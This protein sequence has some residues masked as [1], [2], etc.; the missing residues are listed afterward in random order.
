[1]VAIVASKARLDMGNRDIRNGSC[2]CPSKRAR[3]VALNDDEFGSDPAERRKNGPGNR[4]DMRVR[5][6]PPVAV[7]ADLAVKFEP[8]IGRTKLRMLAGKDQQRW[9][10]ASRKSLRDR[11]ELDGF[12]PG[13]DDQNN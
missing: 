3:C 6:D 12:G 8:V 1:M 5:I 4:F 9:K 11:G 10:A 2:E 7:E 13:A